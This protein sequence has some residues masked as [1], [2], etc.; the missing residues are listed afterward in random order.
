MKGYENMTLSYIQNFFIRTMENLNVDFEYFKDKETGD[1]VLDLKN[2][3][4]ELDVI[5]LNAN[6]QIFEGETKVYTPGR[7]QPIM[8][9]IYSDMYCCIPLGDKDNR[10][11]RVIID[12]D[13]GHKKM[14]KVEY[15]IRNYL[16]RTEHKAYQF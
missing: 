2:L 5:L 11:L 12:K 10:I 15:I 14:L 9:P 8:L 6:F 16:N 7:K 3:Q 4:P 13:Y 1:L